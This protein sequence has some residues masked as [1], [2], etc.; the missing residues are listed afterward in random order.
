M[1]TQMEPLQPLR[2]E[3]ETVGDWLLAVARGTVVLDVVKDQ[4]D[5]LRDGLADEVDAMSAATGTAFTARVGGLGSAVLTDPQ[6]KV[7]VSDAQAFGEWL[8]ACDGEALGL[9]ASRRRVE[10]VDHEAVADWL[11][12]GYGTVPEIEQY[13]KVV[14]EWLPSEE[15]V[16][17][18]LAKDWAK[19]HGDHVRTFDADEGALGDPIPGLT[20]R[21]AKRVLQVKL[22]KKA[23]ETAAAE[24][25]EALE[26]PAIGGADD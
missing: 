4:V 20:V 5:R 14:N 7:T 21:T 12:S 25:R 22:D 10:V 16:D 19:I 13:L 18:L 23:R 15:A 8:A 1:S 26:L 9:V 17:V 2:V 11:V 6:P 3:P 24:V